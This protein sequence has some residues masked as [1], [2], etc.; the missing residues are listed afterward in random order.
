MATMV[1]VIKILE[2]YSKVYPN[3]RLDADGVEIYAESLQKYPAARIEEAMKELVNTC[4]YF[5]S[6]AE[7]HEHAKRR[8]EQNL[9]FVGS[10]EWNAYQKEREAMLREVRDRAI[11]RNRGR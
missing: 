3:F 10:P 6:I 11:G 7:I 4:K 2:R 9:M 8:A 5:P 1:E